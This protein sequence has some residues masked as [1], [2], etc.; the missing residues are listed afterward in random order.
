MPPTRS[1]SLD[2]RSEVTQ[3]LP[4]PQLRGLLD[5]VVFAVF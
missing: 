4:G 5:V 2:L 3:F 1:T